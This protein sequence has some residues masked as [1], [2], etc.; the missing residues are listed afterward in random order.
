[1]GEQQ[2]DRQ[3]NGRTEGGPSSNQ[4]RA[5]AE[6]RPNGLPGEI[7]GQAAGK[8]TA[9]GHYTTSMPSGRRIGV[10][11]PAPFPGH[12]ARRPTRRSSAAKK[13]ARGD[14]S[15]PRSGAICK[16]TEAA[17]QMLISRISKWSVPAGTVTSTLSPFFL[18]SSAWAMGVPIA[19]LPSR[20][21]A[22]CSATIV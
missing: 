5:Q 12:T 4:A 2:T 6:E 16:R 1:M 14:L 20:R 8:P 21:L 19:S 3:M 15:E 7:N 22:S 18:P 9:P 11:P 17:D 13:A 10:V